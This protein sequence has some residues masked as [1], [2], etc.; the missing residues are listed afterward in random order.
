MIVT[1]AVWEKRNLDADCNEITI[2]D[3]DSPA[4][5]KEKI[6][7]YITDYTV[8]RVP[9]GKIDM[10]FLLEDMGF[11][12]IEGMIE[13]FHDLKPENM[14]LTGVAKRIAEGIA[15]REMTE[16]DVSELHGQLR[17]GIFRT[18]RVFADPVF[19]YLQAANR[20]IG[21]IGDEVRNGA[22][23]YV[24]RYRDKN[25]GFFT[26]RSDERGMS[27]PSVT[28]VYSGYE[29]SGFGIG[30]IYSMVSEAAKRQSKGCFGPVSTNN[31]AALK[32]NLAIGFQI[33][34]IVYVYVKHGQE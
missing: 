5:V 7:D 34:R 16:A 13:L 28:G 19:S 25:I 14:L 33:R 8:V 20:Y 23:I 18:D 2:E 6:Q 27:H 9:A 29:N 30:V 21:W 17:A 32:T 4:R 1:H 26:L 24:C 10:M 15:Y 31:I 12:Y 22:K 11:R 3:E